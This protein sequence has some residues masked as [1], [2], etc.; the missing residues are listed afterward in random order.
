METV[1]KL[2]KSPKPERKKMSSSKKAIIFY[3]VEL[4]VIALIFITVA[5]LEVTGVIHISDRHHIIFNFVTLLG[6]SWLIADFIWATFSQKRKTRICY[7][8][9]ILHLPLGIYLISFDVI[10]FVHWN[11]LAYEVYLYGM[12]SAFYYI[13]AC[14]LFEGIYHFFKPIPGLIEEDE[15][16]VVVEEEKKIEPVEETPLEEIETK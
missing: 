10:M 2:E 3:S 5:T 4:I 8:D 9:K 15:P 7:L 6:G 12:T 13:A 1:D 14:Y 16:K 11:V